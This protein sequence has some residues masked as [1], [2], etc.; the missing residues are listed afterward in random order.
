VREAIYYHVALVASH[1][2]CVQLS[3][4]PQW[5]E[6]P[7]MRLLSLFDPKCCTLV[8]TTSFLKYIYDTI[9]FFRLS[10]KYLV[11]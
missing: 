4:N 2:Y 9:D 8:H 3:Q 5:Q 11:N 7:T 10:Y 1:E 6:E